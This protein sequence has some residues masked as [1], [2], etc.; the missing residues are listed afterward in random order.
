MKS[1]LVAR[2][3]SFFIWTCFVSF[4]SSSSNIVPFADE[5]FDALSWW[6]L[7]VYVHV[8]LALCA[9]VAPV[10]LY[11]CECTNCGIRKIAILHAAPERPHPDTT[12][13]YQIL[14]MFV[15]CTSLSP[16]TMQ[17]KASLTMHLCCC[18]FNFSSPGKLNK[19]VDAVA[20]G[21]SRLKRN[22]E[23]FSKASQSPVPRSGSASPVNPHL[24]ESSA[25][26]FCPC[27]ISFR[28]PHGALHSLPYLLQTYQPCNNPCFW[29][30]HV[31]SDHPYC[32]SMTLEA[33]SGSLVLH[34]V[35]H[36]NLLCWIPFTNALKQT[37]HEVG[38]HGHAADYCSIS[39]ILLKNYGM[40]L[41]KTEEIVWLLV[42]IVLSQCSLT[43]W[44]E[45][46]W[47]QSHLLAK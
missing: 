25:Q 16:L 30:R 8:S 26:L 3:A 40:T 31:C 28:S 21:I 42:M 44:S 34:S 18:R 35:A 9:L 14:H 43:L 32:L 2:G 20:E 24:E 23:S 17:Y 46:H 47:N 22:A 37:W 38:L 13:Y 1:P 5:H 10:S 12:F 41:L 27:W 6:M 29:F 15:A 19:D 4:N 45:S 7:F 39:R 36:V 11:P 33:M